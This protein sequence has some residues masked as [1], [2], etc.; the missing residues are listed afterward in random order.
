MIE[1][2]HQTI[3]LHVAE[4]QLLWGCPFTQTFPTGGFPMLQVSKGPSQKIISFLYLLIFRI[5]IE[6]NPGHDHSSS[7]QTALLNVEALCNLS[8]I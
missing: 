1:C 8:R 5:D 6:T 3:M 2:F 4:S 7:P